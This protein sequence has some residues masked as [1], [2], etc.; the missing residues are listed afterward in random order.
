MVES[1]PIVEIILGLAFLF[2]AASPRLRGF[3]RR[4]NPYSV[5]WAVVAVLVAIGLISLY[6]GVSQLL[7]SGQ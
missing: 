1:H 2:V 4:L 5:D 7:N 3:V 6:A